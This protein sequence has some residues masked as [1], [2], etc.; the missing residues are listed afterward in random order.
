MLKTAAQFISILF[1]PLLIPTYML[2]LLMIVNPYLFGVH[3]ISEQNSM[4]L[5]IHT[6]MNTLV[7]PAFAILVM[8]LLGLIKTFEMQ[9]KSERTG[10][11]IIAGIFYLWLFRNFLDN[12]NVPLAFTSFLLGATIALFLAFLLNIF[13]K[14]SAHAVGMGGLLAMVI[15]TMFQFSYD[16]FNLNLWF[17]TIQMNMVTVLM[18]TILIAG[19]VGSARLILKAHIPSDLYGGYLIGFASQIFALRFLF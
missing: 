4:L 5:I 1:H 17:G 6:I 3:D 10:P 12:T 9:D 13:T 18:I 15:I 7:I 11:Y 14:I 8:K 2:V 16:T 19:M